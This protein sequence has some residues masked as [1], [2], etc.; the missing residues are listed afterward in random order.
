MSLLKKKKVS[1]RIVSHLL[2]LIRPK[3]RLLSYVNK[4]TN[5]GLKLNNLRIFGD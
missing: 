5:E 4:K 1:K 2:S 3:P